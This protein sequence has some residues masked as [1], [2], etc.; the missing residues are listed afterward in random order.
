MQSFNQ[1]FKKLEA[2]MMSAFILMAFLV[3]S[4]GWIGQK[5]VDNLIKHIQEVT[6]I[7]LPSIVSLQMIDSGLR[8]L[9][10]AELSLLNPRLNEVVK[11]SQIKAIN[12]ANKKIEEG[13]EKYAKLTHTEQEDEIWRQFQSQKI[14]WQQEHEKFMQFYN[15]FSQMGISNPYKLE[16]SLLREGKKD[17]SEITLARKASSLLEKINIQVFTV[18]LPIFK[19]GIKN[20]EKIIKE[21]EKNVKYAQNIANENVIYTQFILWLIMIFGAI[22]AIVLGIILTWAIAKPIT[23]NLQT[24]VKKI[25]LTSNQIVKALEAQERIA[26]NQVISINQTTVAMEELQKTS[27]QANEEAEMALKVAN[28]V[29]NLAD[30]GTEIV[31]LTLERVN[32][33]DKIAQKINQEIIALNELAKQIRTISEVVG[34]LASQTNML[35]L[36]AAVEAVRSGQAGKGFGV[37]ATEIRRFADLSQQSSRNIKDLVDNIQKAVTSTVIVMDNGT[38]TTS[39]TL[40]QIQKMADIYIAVAQAVKESVVSNQQINLSAQQQTIAIAQVLQ[41]INSL[42]IGV[43]ET[44]TGLKATQIG[45]Q[46]LYEIARNLSNLVEKNR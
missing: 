6:N 44:A 22:L 23:K 10:A 34:N 24:N 25:A 42:K 21:N 29:L 17:S 31:K 15:K 35:A 14:R 46:Q 41:E 1:I 13:Y 7:K 18:N 43:N 40:Q 30:E 9:Q 37:V 26:I 3:F 8:E 32:N 38:K 5:N 12:E 19:S 11:N 2:R 16:L 45:T 28:S 39:I 20:L 27:E 4:V 36:N 33:L